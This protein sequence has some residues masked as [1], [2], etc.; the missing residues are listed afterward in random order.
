MKFAYQMR[1]GV[2]K[3]AIVLTFPHWL[4]DLM[5]RLSPYR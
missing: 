1:N 5:D 4:E 3:V 2:R